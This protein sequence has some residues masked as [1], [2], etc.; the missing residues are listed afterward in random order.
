MRTMLRRPGKGRN[1]SGIDSHVLRPMTTAF[2]IPARDVDDVSFCTRGF[3]ALGVSE[4]HRKGLSVLLVLG[5]Q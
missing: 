5:T 4:R 2:I 1:F 3:V